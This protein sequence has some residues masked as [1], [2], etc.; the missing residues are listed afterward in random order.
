MKEPGAYAELVRVALARDELKLAASFAAEAARL[1]PGSAPR[2]MTLAGILSRIGEHDVAAASYADVLLL[3]PR[4]LAAARALAAIEF[5]AGRFPGAIRTWRR[6]LDAGG[7]EVPAREALADIHLKL[8]D[9]ERAAEELEKALRASPEGS[10]D[11]E[12]LL[13]KLEEMRR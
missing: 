12:R 9:R 6:F 4:N 5:G 2:H 10:P 13:R 3:D 1:D 7:A 8:L 11:R